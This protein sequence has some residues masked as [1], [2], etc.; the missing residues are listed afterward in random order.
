MNRRDFYRYGTITLGGLIAALLAVPGVAYIVSPLRQ[1]S[2]QGD[3]QKLTNLGSLE[4]GVPKSFAIMAERQD[5]WVKYPKEPVGSVWLV[6]Q[7]AG[8]KP[9]VIAFTAECP[10]L[11][12]AVNLAA[13]G[14]S[15]LCPCHT[16]RFDLRGE[17]RE[18]GAPA[19]DGL[20]RRA[21]SRPTPTPRSASSSSA[22][23]P[24]RRRRS[25][26]FNKL[27]E[28]WDERT[29]LQGAP[30]R[31][32]RRAHPGRRALAVRVRLGPEHDV[33]DP[34][35]HRGAPDVLVQPLVLDGLGERLLHQS[36]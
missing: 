9:D 12:C 34:A 31:G 26:L 21:S 18:P 24:R 19:R 1:K 8:T 16:S 17:A 13:D 14:K 4:V 36:E 23:R 27:G 25:P 3:F 5:A 29:G 28:W 6:R 2:K 20:A 32:P 22:S 15:F 33:P 10:H 30:S 7:P 11:G 35:R